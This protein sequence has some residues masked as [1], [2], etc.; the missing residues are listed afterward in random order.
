MNQRR[1]VAIVNKIFWPEGTLIGEALLEVTKQ[2]SPDFDVVVV[3]QSRQSINTKLSQLDEFKRVKFSTSKPISSRSSSLIVRGVDAI[4]FMLYVLISLVYHKP[5]LIYISTNPPVLV[6][7]IVS[8]YARISGAKYLYHV[9]DIHPEA[10]NIISPINKPLFNLLR[11]FD[12]VAL[13]GASSIVTLTTQMT[14]NILLR[15]QVKS[16]IHLVNNPANIGNGLTE[17]VTDTSII[18][19]GSLGRFQNISLL[20]DSIESYLNKGGNLTFLFC[21][22]GVFVS[23]IQALS[24][25]FEHVKYIGPVSPSDAANLVASHKW[26]LLPI[27]DRVTEYAF[28][29]KASTYLSYGC[30]IFAISKEGS[31]ISDWV[32]TNKVGVTVAPN[33][34]DI[35]SGLFQLETIFPSSHKIRNEHFQAIYSMQNFGASIVSLIRT[36]DKEKSSNSLEEI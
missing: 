5:N 8:L 25:K 26:A 19:C 23:R 35:E 21:G 29:S 12:T 20:A 16:P 22:E 27:D 9:Q 31:V 3:A 24:K 33:I 34:A 32:A 15:G 11:Y 13:R 17:N 6:P 1:R 14:K 10:A 30:N 28:P 2:L 4:Y 18:Y 7:L 36:M